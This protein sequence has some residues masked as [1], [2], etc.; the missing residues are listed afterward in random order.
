M[1]T[2]HAYAIQPDDELKPGEGAVLVT[3]SVD[4]PTLL[5]ENGIVASLVPELT[6]ER[7]DSGKVYSLDKRLDGLQA[8]RAYAGSLPPGHYRI[9]S[10]VGRDAF[11][12]PTAGS[13]P[14]FAIDA[15]KV[16]YLGT[17]L[18]AGHR[19]VKP[20]KEWIVY[21]AYTDAPDPVIGQRLLDGLYPELGRAAAASGG[22]EIGWQPDARGPAAAA[23][24]RDGI[25][26]SNSG[27]FDVSP[28]GRDGFLF[29]A[30]NGVVKRWT[31]GDGVRL[32]DTGS[33]FLVRTVFDGGQGRLLAGGEASTL[34]FSGDDGRSWRDVATGLPYGIVLDVA[35]MVGDDVLI[36]LQ[37]GDSA[38]L[39][40][41]R[42]GDASWTRVGGWPMEFKFW[43]GVPGEQPEL[44]V[45]GH[46]VVVTL[47]S[48]QAVFLDLDTGA[49][50]A[51]TAP[52]SIAEANWGP[53][54]ALRCTC[55]H[56][57]WKPFESHD[58]GKTWTESTFNR[59]MVPPVFRD[60]R[61][62]FS[63]RNAFAHRKDA[64][65]VLTHDGGATWT[66]TGTPA[67]ILVGFGQTLWGQWQPAYSAD[68]AVLVLVG[69]LM[70][71]KKTVE[72]GFWSA[73]EGKS[74]GVITN[75]GKWVVEPVARTATN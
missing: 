29:G 62:G 54:G 66:D 34:R 72:H 59:W 23:A 68:G 60:A 28:Y 10:I 7:V 5:N 67:P 71:D 58:L 47:P 52:G 27:M 8:T 70:I 46:G 11:G 38:E 64:S 17:V 36:L 2:P 75:E 30:N 50:H 55:A 31:R 22:M 16:R 13:L 63:F 69:L 39:Y 3:V 74:W 18:V 26:R 56:P 20:S 24:D 9:A 41:G 4:Y 12:A 37:R 51:I 32:L 15:G 43:S 40:R 35:S 73:D 49:T 53:D 19:S 65:V 45:Q 25:R 6:V 48:K 57:G 61:N 21:W 33:P 42:L 44:L 1:S 14:E